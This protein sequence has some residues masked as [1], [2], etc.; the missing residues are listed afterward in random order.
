MQLMRLTWSLLLWTA[1]VSPAPGQTSAHVGIHV[2][3]LPPALRLSVTS[4]RVDFGQQTADVGHVVLDPATGEISHKTAG[5]HQVGQIEVSGREGTAYSIAVD[6]TPFLENPPAQIHFGM[7]WA[8]SSDCRAKAFK[9]IPHA[10]QFT[11]RIGQ[12]S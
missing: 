11:N 4:A 10:P 5:R 6:S 2:E 12:S 8:Q 1:A 9:P 7:Q 3:V